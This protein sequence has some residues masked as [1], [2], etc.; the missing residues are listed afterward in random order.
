MTTLQNL[1]VA[2]LRRVVAI[3]KQIERLQAR[4]DSA[5]NGHSR[6]LSAAPKRRVMSAEGKARIAAGQRLRWAKA[7][8]RTATPAPTKK[9][10]RRKVSPATRARL[11]AVAKA[12]WAKV[13][14][15]G[16]SAL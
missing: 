1:S 13:K 9:T 5:A 10:G 14:A 11:A 4:L 15:L 7:R 3:K 12:R 6:N 16:K 8:A 2:Q